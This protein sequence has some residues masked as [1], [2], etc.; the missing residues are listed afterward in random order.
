MWA[1]GWLIRAIHR[2]VEPIWEELCRKQFARM[3]QLI[4]PESNGI[5]A[6]ML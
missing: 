1:S 6:P 5:R 2:V 4:S 3:G